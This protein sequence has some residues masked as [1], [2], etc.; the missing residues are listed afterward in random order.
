MSTTK[1]AITLEKSILEHLDQLVKSHIFSNRSQ[2]IQKAVQDKLERIKHSRLASQ[3]AKLDP[4]FEKAMAE[5]GFSEELN[6]WP[7]Y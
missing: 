3:C 1:V 5:E 7:E 2:A 4:M 6:K